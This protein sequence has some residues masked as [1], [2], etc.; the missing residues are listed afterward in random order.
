MAEEKKP[1]KTK[2]PS[3][4]K[5]DL[6]N[7]KRNLRNRSFKARVNTAIRTFE[8]ELSGNK[9]TATSHLNTL[10]SLLDKGVKKHVFKLNKINRLKAKFAG[11]LSK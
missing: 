4:K 6:Q 9:E 1:E 5:R 11:R 3:A 2:R 7:A 8:K 10:Y